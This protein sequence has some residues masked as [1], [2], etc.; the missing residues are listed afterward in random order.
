MTTILFYVD[1]LEYLRRG[2]RIGSVSAW[3]GA[4][5]KVKPILTIDG[6]MQ[7]VERVRTAGRA[8]ERLVAHLEQRKES[9]CDVFAV[10]HIQSPAEAERLVQ[11]GREI[12]GNDPVLVSEIAQPLRFLLRAQNLA[13][14]IQSHPLLAVDVGRRGRR[15]RGGG[16]RCLGRRRETGPGGCPSTGPGDTASGRRRWG[17]LAD[18]GNTESCRIDELPRGGHRDGRDRTNTG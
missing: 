18:A 11:R 17:G 5:L 6:G 16:G 9:G 14:E 3:L 1:T 2:G 4:T 13:Q 7:P 12:Y 8:F 10:Q 15:T